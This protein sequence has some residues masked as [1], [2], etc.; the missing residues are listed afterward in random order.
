MSYIRYI[1]ENTKDPK[2][3]PRR[4]Y[5]S[6]HPDDI[7]L[8][9]TVF[10]DI[11]EFCEDFVMFYAD[12]SCKPADYDNT[13]EISNCQVFVIPITRKLIEE[14]EGPLTTEFTQAVRENIPILP[15]LMDKSL[16]KNFNEISSNKQYLLT[17]DP[18][19]KEK[20]QRFLDAT[21]IKD[22]LFES[23]QDIF[24][25]SIF[26]SYCREDRAH[27][28]EL[29]RLVHKD[30]HLRHISLWYD[31]YLTLGKN[32]EDTI[33]EKLNDSLAMIMTITP[34]LVG[35]DNYAFNKE[36]PF[37]KDNDIAVIMAEMV[38]TD[39]TALKSCLRTGDTPPL[40]EA[41]SPDV[42]AE[43]LSRIITE[44]L[45][46]TQRIT[47][48]TE[49]L[50]G[51]A[52]LNG[53]EVEFD[54]KFAEEILNK[55]ASKGNLEAIGQ[56]VNMYARGIGTDRNPEKA[57]K[58]KKKA[59]EKKKALFTLALSESDKIGQSKN[60]KF[61]LTPAAIKFI[62]VK[63]K[64]EFGTYVRTSFERTIASSDEYIL[65]LIEYA[66][67]LAYEGKSDEAD[68]CY[69][70]IEKVRSEMIKRFPQTEHGKERT[71]ALQA[72]HLKHTSVE[73]TDIH[74]AETMY[75]KAKQAYEKNPDSE[76]AATAYFQLCYKYSITLAHKEHDYPKALSVLLKAQENIQIYCTAHPENAT[77]LELH[78]MITRDTG[79][80]LCIIYDR[81]NHEDITLILSALKYYDTGLIIAEKLNNLNKN[82]E[83]TIYSTYTLYTFKG[84]AYYLLEDIPTATEYYMTALEGLKKLEKD[85]R[86]KNVL[87]D[88]LFGYYQLCTRIYT[89]LADIDTTDKNWLRE[90]II[91][92]IEKM[93]NNPRFA[94]EPALLQYRETLTQV[95]SQLI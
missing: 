23:I 91:L 71:I 38:T 61:N 22:N 49:Y 26:V 80:Y 95:L 19:Y 73:N 87:S 75:L 6:C 14:P 86:S 3:H 28:E 46:P 13:E 31:K 4:L 24:F 53:I 82:N 2:N 67:F 20:L 85:S 78:Y 29:I 42:M 41:D 15:I 62:T 25:Y 47:D 5:F 39:R 93:E 89:K 72:E 35:R 56:L 79:Q 76:T 59:V 90:E 92:L 66:R 50:L 32:F 36:Y 84:D 64:E 65:E 63:G 17:S 34:N 21:L 69:K 11:K 60:G 40:I 37:A 68:R 44:T 83:Y 54:R 94:T 30:P 12:T 77:I 33:F 1:P 8:L 9:N 52:Y 48:R 10:S 7:G 74:T 51:M 58:W 43:N 55:S 16:E 27:A 70:I 18:E 88:Y 81:T 45:T 57:L